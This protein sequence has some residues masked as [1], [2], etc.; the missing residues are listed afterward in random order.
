MALPRADVNVIVST[1][2]IDIISYVRGTISLWEKACDSY[3]QGTGMYLLV[4]TTN[5][6]M[7]HDH[8]PS[9]VI[10]VPRVNCFVFRVSVFSMRPCSSHIRKSCWSR[11]LVKIDSTFSCI[12]LLSMHL[13]R[14][15][16]RGGSQEFL[17]FLY[18]FRKVFRCSAVRGITPLS[19][20]R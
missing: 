3:S 20:L 11:C 13:W 16:V 14:P 17:I 15:T 4:G 7:V 2:C 1:L 19:F 12:A 5:K 8:T 10:S 6:G 18:L 9:E